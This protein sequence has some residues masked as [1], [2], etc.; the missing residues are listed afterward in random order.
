MRVWIVIE[1]YCVNN[2]GRDRLAFSDFAKRNRIRGTRNAESAV[3][4]RVRRTRG[5]PLRETGKL[6]TGN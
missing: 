3:V 6:A 2:A 5:V 1:R 4:F